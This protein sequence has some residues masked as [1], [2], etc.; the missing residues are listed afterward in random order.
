MREWIP[1]GE[2][3][4]KEW[5][6]PDYT[7]HALRHTWASWHYC[8]HRDIIKLQ[9]EGDWSD[10]KTVMIYAKLM[11]EAYKEQIEEWWRIGPAI[12]NCP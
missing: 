6:V 1:K 11:P 3:K 5:F 10:I 2:K 7:P 8:V 9:T 4:P 12:G